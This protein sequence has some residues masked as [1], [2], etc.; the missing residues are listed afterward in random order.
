MAKNI[1]DC[2]S[3]EVRQPDCFVTVIIL[4]L[5]PAHLCF[6]FKSKAVAV[7]TSY[8]QR[9]EGLFRKNS[10]ISVRTPPVKTQINLKYH[11]CF[12]YDVIT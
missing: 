10:D 8:R 12:F 9:L 5:V 1:P 4:V 11:H 6:Y 3:K 7:T 2:L